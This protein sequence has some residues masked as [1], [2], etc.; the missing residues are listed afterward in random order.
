MP[1]A[2]AA[3]VH[4]AVAIG[5]QAMLIKATI[6]AVCRNGLDMIGGRAGR[7]ALERESNTVSILQVVSGALVVWGAQTEFADHERA[8]F[9]RDRDRGSAPQCDRR[10]GAGSL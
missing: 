1:S 9:F 6:K 10:A 5:V 3:M 7:G 4:C 2:V 8:F